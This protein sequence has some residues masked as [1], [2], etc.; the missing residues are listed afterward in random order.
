MRLVVESFRGLGLSDTPT[1]RHRPDESGR[2]TLYYFL[3]VP[4]R[5]SASVF[6]L[7]HFTTETQRLKGTELNISL[8]K[9]I[10]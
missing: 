6:I 7:L 1:P 5:L 9:N 2:D 10:R 8:L 3:S 4:L